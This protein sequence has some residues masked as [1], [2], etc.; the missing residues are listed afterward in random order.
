MLAQKYLP[1]SGPAIA[2]QSWGQNATLLQAVNRRY[3]KGIVGPLL[4]LALQLFR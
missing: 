2:K 3:P 1:S 4:R